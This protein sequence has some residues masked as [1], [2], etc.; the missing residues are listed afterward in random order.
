MILNALAAL[1][2]LTAG[3]NRRQI[4]LKAHEAKRKIADVSHIQ[5]AGS[6]IRD[7]VAHITIRNNNP[8][9]IRGISI[10]VEYYRV[11]KKSAPPE[12]TQGAFLEALI[13]PGQEFEFDNYD[14]DAS[15]RLVPH[16]HGM[17]DEWIAVPRFEYAER[18]DQ[19]D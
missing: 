3:R 4:L 14:P 8:Y 17:P 7:G 9:P 10:T 16:S 18:V 6:I 1:A 12:H 11:N 19:K 13:M 5:M 15:S 2:T